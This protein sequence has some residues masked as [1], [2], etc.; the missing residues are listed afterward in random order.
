MLIKENLIGKEVVNIEA[1]VIGKVVDVEFDP[2]C[3]EVKYLIL[4]KGFLPSNNEVK[5][6][7]EIIKK[8]GDKV[9]LRK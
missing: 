9:I 3:F 4:K 5:V 1:N 8:I 6:P 2:S 7:F